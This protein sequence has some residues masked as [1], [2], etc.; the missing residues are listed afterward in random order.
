MSVQRDTQSRTVQP[1][2]FFS[3]SSGKVERTNDGLLSAIDKSFTDAGGDKKALTAY[4]DNAVFYKG[5]HLIKGGK[6]AQSKKARGSRG[7]D[8]D[9]APAEAAPEVE[10]QNVSCW[11]IYTAQAALIVTVYPWNS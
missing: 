2:S 6:A 5:N 1:L 11:Y 7:G 4:L 9:E 3:N 8:D 10:E